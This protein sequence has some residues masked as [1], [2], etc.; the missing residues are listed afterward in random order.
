MPP[1]PLRLVREEPERGRVRL[2]EPEAGEADELVE[3]RVR[4]LG[5]DAL[6]R[7]AGDEPLAV[8]LERVEAPLPAHRPAQA[9]RLPD[10]EAGER[11]RDLEH[12]VL[13]DDDAERRAQRL[14][15][16]LVVDRPDVGRVVAQPLARVDVRVHR[17]S[18]DRP[19]PDERDLAR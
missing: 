13:E 8:R 10:R 19:R 5:V 12:L 17:L 14:A 11:D 6:R 1:Q 18:L 3:D 15:Q 2:R 7:R 9:L 16:E 4:D